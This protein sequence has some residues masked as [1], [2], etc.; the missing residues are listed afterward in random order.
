MSTQPPAPQSP[1]RTA[2]PADA[3]APPALAGRLRTTAIVFMVIAAASPLTVMSGAAPLGFLLGN[4]PGFPALF[5]VG[6]GILVLFA[7]GLVAMARSVPRT[8]TFFTYVGYGLG[9]PAGLAA[10]HLAL[11]SYTAVQLAVYAYLGAV[12]RTTV[13]GAGGPDVPWWLW[14]L[15]VVSVC[16]LMGYRKIDVSSRVLGVL[17]VG[18]LLILVALVVAVLLRGGGVDGLTPAPFDPAQVTRG[19]PGVGLML[20]M[21][22]FVGF[23]ATTVYRDEAH[24]P[25][26]TIPRATYV[27]VVGIGVFYALVTWAMVATWGV[28]GIVAAASDPA[29]FLSRTV[30]ATLGPVGEVVVEVLLVTS[31]FACV[32]S[33]HNVLTRYQYALSSTGVLPAGLSSVHPRHGSPSVSSF[34]QST[35]AFSLV[36]VCAL[37]GL[38]PVLQIFTWFSGLVPLALAA[39][40]VATS[41]AVL[42]YFRRHPE[43][44]PPRAPRWKT[45]VAPV[46]GALGL[47]LAIS[48]MV[49]YFPMLVGDHDDAGAPV[50]G[51]V[52][53]S[54]LAALVVVPVA[55][56]VQ[57]AVLRARGVPLDLE[58]IEAE[59]EAAPAARTG[60][61]SPGGGAAGRP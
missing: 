24:D 8:G 55:G 51:P 23:E 39:L 33:F 31:L 15:A 30:G 9:R 47:L 53:L 10:A 6:A 11:V 5:L 32:L 35:T 38:D 14:S 42:R 4:G 59:V 46:L 26:R 2:G 40:M 36:A 49:R 50:F 3:A 20:A 13:T 12:L 60:E 61:V 22:A 54:L 37:V 58:R 1:S 45:V 57:A 52:S 29:T 19:A 56:L 7:V 34:V 48:L 21:S 41:V 28:D 44:K 25:H 43:A 17:L 27:S 18:E 16:G